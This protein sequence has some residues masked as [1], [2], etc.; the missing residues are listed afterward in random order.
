MVCYPAD[1]CCSHGYPQKMWITPVTAITGTCK[2]VFP[3]DMS[4]QR[5]TDLTR[6]IREWAAH[7][8]FSRRGG[9]RRKN[10]VYKL[11]ES[12]TDL[13][14]VQ[15]ALAEM[16]RLRQHH[17][18]SQDIGISPRR[19]EL[20][21]YL[22]EEHGMDPVE[23]DEQGDT[24]L[25]LLCRFDA[26]MAD[27]RLLF[28]HGAKAIVNASNAGGETPLLAH[29]RSSAPTKGV[30]EI[31][32]RNGADPDVTDDA[33]VTPFTALQAKSARLP[34][35]EALADL[36]VRSSREHRSGKRRAVSAPAPHHNL[37]PA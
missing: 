10:R 2:P 3:Y 14:G 33:G 9:R 18:Q 23:A 37:R 6:A 31:L 1:S 17:Y 32:L 4:E 25:H 28:G 34:M 24:L 15:G 16:Y 8:N 27:L 7:Q 20:L 5:V 19:R 30:V 21:K 13:N 29:L 11:L 35:A 36:L 12:G 26:P 22:L